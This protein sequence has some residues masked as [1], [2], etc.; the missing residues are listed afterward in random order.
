M[1]FVHLL[2]R[3]EQNSCEFTK[4]QQ[5]IDHRHEANLLIQISHLLPQ[6]QVFKKS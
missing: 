1:K 3:R 4:I 5:N 2:T 6:V